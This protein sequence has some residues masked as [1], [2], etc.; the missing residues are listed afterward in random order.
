MQERRSLRQIAQRVAIGA[1]AVLALAA[2]VRHVRKSHATAMLQEYMIV[3]VQARPQF[4][5]RRGQ[6]LATEGIPGNGYS[7]RANNEEDY[8]DPYGGGDVPGPYGR[9]NDPYDGDWA[10]GP[11]GGKQVGGV[12]GLRMVPRQGLAVD[13]NIWDENSEMGTN[14]VYMPPMPQSQVDAVA[15]Q[16][17]DAQQNAAK[18]KANANQGGQPQQDRSWVGTNDV[19]F[20]ANGGG[21]GFARGAKKAGLSKTAAA[22]GAKKAAP[23][24]KATPKQMSAVQRKQHAMKAKMMSLYR[25]EDPHEAEYGREGYNQLDDTVLPSYVGSGGPVIGVDGL[26]SNMEHEWVHHDEPMSF[27]CNPDI[28]GCETGE[29]VDPLYAHD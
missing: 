7:G 18:H 16:R 1:A 23:K 21:Y 4:L 27:A 5:L 15:R 6:A 13:H 11:L 2:V 20:G 17:A 24:A 3:P 25:S 14:S 22:R 10:L 29:E 28:Y 9:V 26:A 19:F 12:Q 8:T